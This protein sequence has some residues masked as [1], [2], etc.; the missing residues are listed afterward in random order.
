MRER[1]LER[2]ARG[3]LSCVN[4][5]NPATAPFAA[6]MCI[7]VGG[8]MV[9][10]KCVVCGGTG[11]QLQLAATSARRCI[12]VVSYPYFTGTTERQSTKKGTLGE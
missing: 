9:G 11:G 2:H 4:F 6:D 1:A 10:G 7:G 3:A 5:A 12:V 8:G